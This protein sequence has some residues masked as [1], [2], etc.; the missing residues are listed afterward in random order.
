MDILINQNLSFYLR[1]SSPYV[2]HIFTVTHTRLLLPGAPA[3][4]VRF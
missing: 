1:L 4:A 2:Y 3:P